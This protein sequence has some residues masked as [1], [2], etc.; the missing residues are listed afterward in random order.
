[1]RV[2][3]VLLAAGSG[4]RVGAEKNKLLLTY[5]GKPA[6]AHTF[7]AFA[8]AGCFDEIII[9][10]KESERKYSRWRSRRDCGEPNG[11]GAEIRD[12]SPCETRSS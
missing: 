2:S 9:V 12:S 4:S 7:S 1:M 10:T 3:A 11:R 6:I 8:K 5:L